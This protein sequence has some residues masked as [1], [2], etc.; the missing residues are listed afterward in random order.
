MS[1]PQVSM[2]LEPSEDEQMLR[3]AVRGIASSYGAA[4][5]REKISKEEPPVELWDELGR[6]GF[7][8][9]NIPTEYGGGGMGMTGL[10]AVQEELAQAECSLALLVVSPAIAGS[11][12]VRHG[13]EQQRKEWLPGLA[14]A[15][16]KI[17]F[18]VTEPDAGSNTHMISTNATRTESGTWRLNGQKYYISGVE[19]ADSI[20]VV[21]RNRMPDGN[22]GLPLLFLVPVDA[23]G[24]TKQ[25]LPTTVP[26]AEWQWT[27]YFDDVE[28]DDARLVGGDTG[29]LGALF[30]GLNPERIMGAAGGVGGARVALDKATDYAKTRK[31]WGDAPI[32]AHQA[33]AHP[34]AETWMEYEQAKLM[35][36]K[37]CALYDAGH[38]K[39]G[40]ACNMAKFAAGEVAVKAA[41]R[42]IQTHG[43]NGMSVEYGL[44][45][46]W[47]GARLIQIAPVSRE[48]IL[49]H[50]AQHTLGLPKSY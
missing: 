38:P 41:D 43:G 9:V 49:N 5:M 12:L 21:A 11:I 48:M 32:G 2:L 34:L 28:V 8:G 47:L 25:P 27:L 42:A 31:V 23:P 17:A 19:H 37:A 18:A 26:W 30:D 10:A 1:A 6:A 45:D 50:V 29:G 22:L 7:L 14:S 33:I 40:T 15:E 4:Y 39:A 16:K 20:L 13:S 3:D 36:Q 35:L 24:L 44:T 46:L